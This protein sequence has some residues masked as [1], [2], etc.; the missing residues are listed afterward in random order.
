MLNVKWNIGSGPD[1][2][3]PDGVNGPLPPVGSATA[4]P[5]LVKAK[6]NSNADCAEI[7]FIFNLF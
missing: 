7:I 2:F 4:K 6:T 1:G 3:E 5:A